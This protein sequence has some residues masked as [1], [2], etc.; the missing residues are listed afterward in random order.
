MGQ[1]L[2]STQCTSRLLVASCIMA[3]QSMCTLAAAT[4]T[5]C[6]Y[7]TSDEKTH[8]IRTTRT[9]RLTYAAEL[10]RDY[11]WTPGHAWCC[12]WPCERGHQWARVASTNSRPPSD[13]AGKLCSFQYCNICAHLQV[14]FD[15]NCEYLRHPDWSNVLPTHSALCNWQRLSCHQSVHGILVSKSLAENLLT[16]QKMKS[17]GCDFELMS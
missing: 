7:F 4:A 13:C 3:H 15:I 12:N 16:H 17:H 6:N 14:S 9:K 5:C 1:H 8:G 11:Q 2:V 10:C